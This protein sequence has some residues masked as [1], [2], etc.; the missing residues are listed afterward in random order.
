SQNTKTGGGIQTQD[1]RPLSRPLFTAEPQLDLTTHCIASCYHKG[2]LAFETLYSDGSRTL[3]TVDLRMRS[4][5]HP[6][7]KR[8][9]YG[10]DGRFSIRSDHF[11]LDYPFSTTVHISTGCTGVLGSARHVL[12]ATNCVHEGK[13]YV[14]GARK[15]KVGFISQPT[16]DAPP[17]MDTPPP[18]NGTNPGC[19]PNP[20]P[21]LED[22]AGRLIHF[23][24]FD[25]DRPGELVYR[26]CSVE[27][28]SSD[29]IY[30]NCEAQPGASSSGVCSHIWDSALERWERRVIGVFSGHQ[31]LEV[32]GEN[33][34]FNV[35]VWF[36][37]LK[38]SQ[39]CYWLHR[40]HEEC[41]QDLD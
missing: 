23:S 18:M 8:Q 38:I 7:Q 32:D 30:Q 34:D 14:K 22:L 24:G 27:D 3:T 13:D 9:I 28:E 20:A 12:T 15:L 29:L 39:I 6:G 2:W 36:M 17:T 11:L 40:S 5:L 41:S 37:L 1:R 31:W 21:S 10:E 26:F 33:C 16:M 35:V 4:G 25:S 19:F